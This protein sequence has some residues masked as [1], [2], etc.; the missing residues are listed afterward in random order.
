[1][2]QSALRRTIRRCTAVLAIPVA[3]IPMVFVAWLRSEGHLFSDVVLETA[4]EFAL[5]VLLGAV[6]YLIG[7]VA[8]QIKRVSNAERA[9]AS[10]ESE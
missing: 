7:S 2:T 5:V 9:P 1:M 4:D 8:L 3:L 6:A 10:H